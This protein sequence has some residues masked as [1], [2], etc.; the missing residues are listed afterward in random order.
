METTVT[1]KRDTTY[2]PLFAAGLVFLG[3]TAIDFALNGEEA[4]WNFQFWDGDIGLSESAIIASPLAG[5]ITLLLLKKFNMYGRVEVHT[6]TEKV[7]VEQTR[8]RKRE[9]FIP[10]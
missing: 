9:V 1:T 6:T 7:M 5:Y 8:K 4:V 2:D 3:M 10:N